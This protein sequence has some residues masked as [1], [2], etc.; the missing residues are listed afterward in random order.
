MS[1]RLAHACL[2]GVDTPLSDAIFLSTQLRALLN[3]SSHNASALRIGICAL[4]QWA[5]PGPSGFYDSMLPGDAM[6]PHLVTSLGWQHDPAFYSTPLTS[7]EPP[8]SRATTV[9]SDGRT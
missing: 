1:T 3:T 2:R 8:K 9:L 7:A 5:D 4:L 6:A